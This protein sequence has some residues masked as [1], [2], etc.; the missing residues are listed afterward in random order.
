MNSDR[1]PTRRPPARLPGGPYSPA[2]TCW[3]PWRSSPQ[4]HSS[5]S[6]PHP[7]SPP[8]S[9][10][11]LVRFRNPS[12]FGLRNAEFDSNQS[13]RLRQGFRNPSRRC[14][15]LGDHR[16]WN[17]PRS[18]PVSGTETPY[19]SRLFLS[20]IPPVYSSRLFLSSIPRNFLP[21]IPP[22]YSSRL[23]IAPH[24]SRPSNLV[25]PPPPNPHT[26]II[27]ARPLSPNH[28]GGR[29]GCEGTAR[30]QSIRLNPN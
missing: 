16:H 9:L 22:V 26:L 27:A 23:F 17:W 30:R 12:A 21:S 15:V 6:L 1:I 28:P 10:S 13:A 5:L 4:P 11:I 29:Q 7:P 18:L 2:L 25:P 3:P 19:S 14:L 20:S 24:P 8:L